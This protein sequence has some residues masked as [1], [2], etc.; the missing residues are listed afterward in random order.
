MALMTWYYV[1]EGQQQ[2]PVS[3]EDL[4]AKISKGEITPA[5]LTWRQGMKE[6]V[7]ILTVPELSSKPTGSAT[8]LP[9]GPSQPEVSSEP[10]PYQPPT[11]SVSTAQPTPLAPEMIALMKV[12]NY[13][14]QSILATLFCCLPFGVVAIV[15][16]S[17]VDGLKHIGDLEAAKAASNSAKLWINISVFA[18]LIVMVGSWLVSFLGEMS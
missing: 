13:L 4:R 14:A 10:S 15:Y 8:S 16:A 12:P 17:K 1:S 2:G 6:W 18:F 9:A 7:P 11:A 3:T 5:D